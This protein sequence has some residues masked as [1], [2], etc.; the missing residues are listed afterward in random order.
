MNKQ[1]TELI[2]KVLSAFGQKDNKKPEVKARDIVP[3]EKPEEQITPEIIARAIAVHGGKDA[4]TS[5]YANIISEETNKSEFLKDN[6]YL[7][8]A[9]AHLE[10][11]SG[12]NI[13]RSNNDL[14]WGINYPGNNAIFAKMNREDVI[15]R[16]LSGLGERSPYYKEFRT[17]Q[18]LTNEQIM[19][20]GSIYEPANSNYPQNLLNAIKLIETQLQNQ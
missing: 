20:L 6:P 3:T 11:S 5:K 9:I 14:N 10:T 19:K 1:I 16:A 7:A 12:R 4:P 2:K 8:P 17:G 18:P 15:R 13:T